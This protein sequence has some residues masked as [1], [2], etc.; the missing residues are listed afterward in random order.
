MFLNDVN[1]YLEL[2][3][4]PSQAIPNNPLE[5]IL[6]LFGPLGQPFKTDWCLV[7]D[8]IYFSFLLSN[9]LAYI[10]F[11]FP[12]NNQFGRLRRQP[13]ESRH[14]VHNFGLQYNKRESPALLQNKFSFSRLYQRSQSVSVSYPITS[15]LLQNSFP[16]DHN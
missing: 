15:K 4:A 7:K 16:I 5:I 1:T 11:T 8:I 10:A 9:L 14:L 2:N 13:D 6:E 3:N 12:R